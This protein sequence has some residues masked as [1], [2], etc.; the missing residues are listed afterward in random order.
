VTDCADLRTLVEKLADSEAT[1]AEK[2]AAEAHLAQCPSCRSHVEFLVFLSGESRAALPEPPGSYWEHLPRKVLAR[3]DA[4]DRRPSGIWRILLAPSILR[5]G[6]L[7]ATLAL[8]TALGITMLRDGSKLPAPAATAPAPAV[9]VREP[10]ALPPAEPSDSPPM[11]RDEAVPAAGAAVLPDAR[12]AEPASEDSQAPSPGEPAELA[13]AFEGNEEAAS[14]LRPADSANRE[15]AKV[16]ESAARARSAAAAS[17]GAAVED[18]DA[19]RRTVATLGPEASDA[20]YRLALCSF[21]RH[22]RD[23]TEELRTLAVEDAE[24]F[25]AGESEGS[26]AEEIRGKLRRIR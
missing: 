7:G 11:A 3:I 17:F 19:L 22:K 2:R 1:A 12:K 9:E 5:W 8:V 18:C 20:R 15:N 23:A 16:Q 25:L 6:P 24:E 26:R 21:E 10:E 14:S 4:E 13:V